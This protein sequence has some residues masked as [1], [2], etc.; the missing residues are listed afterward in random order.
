VRDF[1]LGRVYKPQDPT[2]VL[3]HL[4]LTDD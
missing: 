2:Q 4:Y 1:G 3:M